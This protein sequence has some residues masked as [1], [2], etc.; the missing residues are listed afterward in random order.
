MARI[1]FSIK[2]KINITAE[3]CVRIIS[4]ISIVPNA[5]LPAKK[6]PN[7][8]RKPLEFKLALK[9]NSTYRVEIKM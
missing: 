5:K 1:L 4:A 3:G 6:A 9:Q 8:K 7:T 2:R